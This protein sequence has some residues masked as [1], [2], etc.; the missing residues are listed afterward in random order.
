ML[1]FACILFAGLLS[2]RDYGISAD[3]PAVRSYG[4]QTT[5]YL[6]H[7]G[8]PPSA[9]DWQ[10][11]GPAW[12]VLLTA[13]GD[14]LGVEQVRTLWALRH[15]LTFLLFYAGLMALYRIGLK[16]FGDWRLALL[17]VAFMV[18]SPRVFAH[19]FYN[20]KDTPA[21]ALFTL[22]M[23]TLLVLVERK[24]LPF[25]MLHGLLCGLLI[26][27]RVAGLLV[28]AL[29]VCVLLAGGR[30]RR[31][32]GM[33]LLYL[34]V[35][36]IAT[37]AVWPALWGEPL[38]SFLSAFESS[39]TRAGG[40]YYFG[41]MASGPLLSGALWHYPFVWIAIT[42]PI[43]Y[44]I[45][46]LA[47]CAAAGWAAVMEHALRRGAGRAPQERLCDALTLCWFWVPL[48]A[49]YSLRAGI[50]DEWRHLLFIYPA[51]LLLSLRGFRAVMLRCARVPAL[52]AAFLPVVGA[53]I[54]FTAF[55][56]LRFHP[57][58]YAYFSV[59]A[60]WVEGRFELDYWSLSYRA[61]LEWIAR[62]DP[63]ERIPVFTK[64]RAGV[65][66]ADMLPPADLQR[67]VFV[68]EEEA[69]YVLDNFRP[70]DYRK[71]TEERYRAHSV[72]VDG[73]EILAV[74]AGERLRPALD[75]AGGAS[76]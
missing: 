41:R 67:I 52:H 39:G 23:Y 26:S 25:L 7:G 3:E 70:E 19:S 18:L 46:F 35:T 37:L 11:Y 53:G 45:F 21:M 32:W 43:F 72:T 36:A 29:T 9:Y 48:L 55:W 66:G 47:G 30:G 6:F 59:P 73:V 33:V 64:T 16:M 58:Q 56:M 75:A 34:T 13:A 57:F 69:D 4:E 24:T 40:G 63:R 76:R 71:T 27:T 65:S 1:V 28:P 50:F 60:R 17:G 5:D 20:P 44:T 54:L 49:L 10:F 68:P 61:G 15:L 51:F 31:T 62:T 38:Q 2:F 8:E 12:P 22:C 14:A 74:Y 42:T